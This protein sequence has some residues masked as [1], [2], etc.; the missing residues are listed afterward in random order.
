MQG[1]EIVYELSE[2]LNSLLKVSNSGIAKELLK[3]VNFGIRF[4]N[5]KEDIFI[6]CYY[7]LEG[8]KA[9]AVDEWPKEA[10]LKITTHTFKLDYAIKEEWGGDVFFI[11]YG[12]DIDIL[13][14]KCLKDNLDIVS[15]R[16][17]SRFP[18]ASYHMIREPLRAAKYFINNHDFARLAI[19]QKIITRGNPNKLPYN[20]RAHWIN[21]SKCDVCKLC[22]I[23][24]LSDEFAG[25]LNFV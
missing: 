9:E 16:L 25:L 22:D 5:V 20:E 11:G 15:I 19:K 2:K 10:N 18:A 6:H 17:L 1:P 12:A 4:N 3:Q 23:P 13:D 8:L 7:T 21:K 24:L 14:Q